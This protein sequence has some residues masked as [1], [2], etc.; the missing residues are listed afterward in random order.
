MIVSLSWELIRLIETYQVMEIH[1]RAILLRMLPLTIFLWG[2]IF[3]FSVGI[4]V[5]TRRHWHDGITVFTQGFMQ[6]KGKHT[7]QFLWQEAERLDCSIYK[8]QFAGSTV[9]IRINLIFENQARQSIRLRNDYA[10]MN[11][12][13]DQFR[14]MTLPILFKK[15][16]QRLDRGESLQFHPLLKINPSGVEIKERLFPFQNLETPS[17]TNGVIQIVTKDNQE[18]VFKSKVNKLENLD[19]LIHLFEFPPEP[20]AGSPSR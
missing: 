2:V 14:Q 3:P 11:Q 20:G 16:H 18:V 4:I 8:I 1:G 6:K 7:R 10:Q 12:M 5:L 13:I 9:S 17:I 15:A 19:V